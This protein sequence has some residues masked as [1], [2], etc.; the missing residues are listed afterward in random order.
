MHP[1]SAVLVFE[2]HLPKGHLGAP[3]RG[4]GLLFDVLDVG[5]ENPKSHEGKR[6]HRR[7]HTNGV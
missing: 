4:S 3:G 5:G 2:Q 1:A 6:R 7:Y